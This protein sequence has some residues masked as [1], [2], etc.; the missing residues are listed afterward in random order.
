[1]TRKLIYK[2]KD[3]FVA[4]VFHSIKTICGKYNT[5]VGVIALVDL[6]G[7]RLPILPAGFQIKVFFS[8]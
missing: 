7:D 1:V 2:A 5:Q 3:T 4:A 6:I 8:A